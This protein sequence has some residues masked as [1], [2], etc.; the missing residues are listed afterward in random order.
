MQG[1]GISQYILMKQEKGSTFNKWSFNT[2][3]TDNKGQTGIY[4]GD[5]TMQR[6][7]RTLVEWF[8]KRILTY[9]MD[10]LHAFA[11][12]AAAM[13]R[14]ASRTYMYGIWKVDLVRQLV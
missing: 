2:F 9:K 8:T 1:S 13:K 11:G 6:S 5:E 14:W 7:W 10:Q 12:L 4:V 3:Q